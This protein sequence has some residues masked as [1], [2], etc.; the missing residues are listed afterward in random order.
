[1]L[2]SLAEW[3]DFNVAMAGATAAL[4]G[5]LINRD[6]YDRTLKFDSDLEAKVMALTP[7]QV[8]EAFRRN[9]DPSAMILVKAGDFKKAHVYQ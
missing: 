6:R 3:S 5:L 4:A 8:S 1:M 7:A 9:I 2:E